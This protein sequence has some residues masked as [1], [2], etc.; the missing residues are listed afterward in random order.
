MLQSLS[1]LQMHML[2]AI[3]LP[4]FAGLFSAVSI[5][6]MWRDLVVLLL[7]V[8]TF[9][10]V[11]YVAYH[12]LSNDAAFE[13]HTLTLASLAPGLTVALSIEQTGLIF[14]LIASGLWVITSIYASGYMH[15]NNEP[16]QGR[17]F[18][19]FHSA[20][21]AALLIAFSGN[22]FTLFLGYE[23]LSLSTFP[24]V[25]HKQSAD[26]KKAGRVYLGIL[27][28]TSI[29]F[30]L[31]LVIIVWAVTGSTE[32]V[33]GGTGLPQALIPIALLLAVF[34]V[35]KT[36]IMPL[37]RWLPAAMVAP[38]PVSALLHAV[39]VVKAG[40]FALV[41]IIYFTIG[42]EGPQ[43]GFASFFSTGW[44]TYLAGFTVLMASLI[45]CYQDSIK[46]RLAF[47]TISQ[48]SYIVMAA[49]LFSV[50]A[51]K[52]A[53]IHMAVHAVSKITLFFAAG[54]I[55]TAQKK[56]L[57]SQL[58]GIG[59]TMPIT[60]VCFT[61]GALSMI[62]LPPTAGLWSKWFIMQAALDMQHYFVLVVLLV[63]TLL[64]AL[65]FLPIIFRAYF[66]EAEEGSAQKEAP[67]S[68]Q[69]AIATTAFL[70]LLLFFM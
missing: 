42:M 49:S 37:H 70:T 39:A 13:A 68:M 48:L 15:H 5:S 44:L 38:T 17:F 31:P 67:F 29:S 66:T 51:L 64:N 56:T 47:S 6:R 3:C 25:T 54:N 24:L 52:A 33:F 55:Y 30:F 61:I 63:S 8:G 7:A 11:A 18:L 1:I 41:K 20:I 22:L 19:C 32:F 14:A 16:R 57:V 36:A 60:L 34:G 2:I 21:A 26:A 53:L 35:A 59:R 12:S 69:L 27:L 45:A 23:I 9:M 43:A 10:L 58:N 4:V 65:Y 28:A 46:K 62:G 40:V 50:L